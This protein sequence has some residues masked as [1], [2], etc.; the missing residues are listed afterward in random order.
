MFEHEPTK[1]C[2]KCSGE[3]RANDAQAAPLDRVGW[4]AYQLH[5]LRGNKPDE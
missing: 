1:Q 4:S 5:S 2:E 3:A